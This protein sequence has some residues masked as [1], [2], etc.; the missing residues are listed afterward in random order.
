MSLSSSTWSDELFF[1][2]ELP[3]ENSDEA[4]EEGSRR[5]ERYVQLADGVA[6]GEGI[7][8]VAAI[9]RSF[10]V[11]EDFGAYQSAF[12][13]L[14]R[15]PRPILGAGAAGSATTLARIPEC[16]SGNILLLVVRLGV[17]CID[18]FNY[19]FAA[20]DQVEK[21]ELERLIAFHE[22]NEWLA[23]DADR[24]KLAAPKVA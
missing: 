15:F 1:C 8:G 3:Q 5:W 4:M 18:A 20:L 6:G 13:A 12:S 23:E 9:I 11:E 19:R 10:R 2:G 7:E 17:E 21:E 16:W 24:G 22:A 14:Q